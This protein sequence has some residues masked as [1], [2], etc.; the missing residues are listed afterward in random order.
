MGYMRRLGMTAL[1]LAALALAIPLM[2]GAQKPPKPGPTDLTIGARPA[3][4]TFG[5]S[6]TVSGHLRT[7]DKANKPVDLQEKPAGENAFKTVQTKNTEQSGAYSFSVKPGKTTRYR[8]VARVAPPITSG[9]I[10]VPVRFRVSLR[11]SDY[12]PAAGQRVRFS[13]SVQPERDGRL[14]YIQR[15]TSTGS[16]RTVARTTLRDAGTTRS[17]YARSFRLS[18]DGT[19][20]ARVLRD[21]ENATG[22]SGTRTANVH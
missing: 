10:E 11:L 18:R 15:R 16:W 4:I 5:Q 7:Q 17:V 22:T 20:R 14:V 6:T 2:A 13:G 1:L 8:V 9:E 21:A 3:A 19:F 12:T